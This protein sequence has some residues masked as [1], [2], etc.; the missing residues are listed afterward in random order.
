[1]TRN[2][3][4]FFL[5][6]GELQLVLFGSTPFILKSANIHFFEVQIYIFFEVLNI[7][8]HRAVGPSRVAQDGKV[9]TARRRRTEEGEINSASPRHAA[10]GW[11]NARGRRL[12]VVGLGSP[13]HHTHHRPHHRARPAPPAG[14]T[15]PDPTRPPPAFDHPE[16]P[17][18]ARRCGARRRRRPTRHPRARSRRP[19]PPSPG[20]APSFLPSVL[21]AASL[22]AAGPAWRDSPGWQVVAAGSG[23]ARV[24]PA[25]RCSVL[26]GF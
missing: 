21:P 13:S 2:Y 25:A 26:G 3:R 8:G 16:R 19:R 1:L 11:V 7:F 22:A 14:P 4:V 6:G 5:F 23:P 15:R 10:I 9:Q 20:A 18:C 17:R 12:V 24:S